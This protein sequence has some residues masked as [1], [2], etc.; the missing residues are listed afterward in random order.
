M[1]FQERHRKHVEEQ[2]GHRLSWPWIDRQRTMDTGV[3]HAA[4]TT[5]PGYLN[6]TTQEE[7]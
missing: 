6:R 1:D 4:V 5:W 3:T 7:S 2:Y